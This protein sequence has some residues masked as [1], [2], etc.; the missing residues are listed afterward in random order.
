MAVLKVERAGSPVLKQVCE[1]VDKFDN[2]LKHFLDDMADTMYS[3]DGIGLAAPQ[4]GRPIRAIIVDTQD[5]KRGLV[6]LINPNIIRRSDEIEEDKEGC[7]S[8]PDMFGDV[9]RHVKITVEYFNR[10]GKKQKLTATGLMA[11]CIQHEIDHLNG[12]L[13]IE[14]AKR[15]RRGNS[16]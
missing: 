3:Q 7:L 12:V 2:E 5:S 13:F 1:P 16:D 6:E 9:K 4:V 15:L 14:K 8:V 11:R 10:R